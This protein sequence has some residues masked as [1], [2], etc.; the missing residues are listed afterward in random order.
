M[1]EQ[2]KVPVFKAAL[3]YGAIVG[4]V[5][6]VVSVLLNLL[7]LTFATW[8]G[9]LSLAITFGILVYVLRAYREEYLGGY[10]KYGQLVLMSLYIGI[11]SSVLVTIYTYINITII[12]PDFIQKTINFTYDKM[13]N[14]PRMTDEVLDMV[15][16]RMESKMTVSRIIIQGAIGGIVWTTILGLIVG[17]FTRK[18]DPATVI[19]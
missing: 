7:D 11:V 13:A 9:F 15:M 17:A 18:Q 8:A 4:F 3:I 19:N 14:N 1:E 2:A 5:S 6:I 16:E 10:A 12:D